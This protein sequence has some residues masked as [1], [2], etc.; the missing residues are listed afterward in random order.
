MISAAIVKDLE[1][2]DFY[3]PVGKL[4]LPKSFRL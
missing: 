4:G 3:R 2:S 1:P